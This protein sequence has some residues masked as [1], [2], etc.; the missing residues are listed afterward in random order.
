SGTSTPSPESTSCGG[1]GSTCSSCP[2]WGPGS[3]S[4][5]WRWY[6]S[7]ASRSRTEVIHG[8][9]AC[10]GKDHGRAAGLPPPVRALAV[11]PPA[12]DPVLP[13]R[14]GP[15]LRPDLPPHRSPV[16]PLRVRGRVPPG[17]DLHRLPVLDPGGRGAAVADAKRFSAHQRHRDEMVLRDPARARR[18]DVIHR[19][20]PAR[21]SADAE[22]A[23][24]VRS[25]PHG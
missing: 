16:L 25:G 24:P 1:T 13:A 11:R 22:V 3:W 7:R 21:L 10:E 20:A 23:L 6:G 14:N 18:A 9:R 19:P 15:G 5:I 17:V 12:R 2:S 4:S 8:N